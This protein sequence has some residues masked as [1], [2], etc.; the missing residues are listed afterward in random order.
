MFSGG[1]MSN[2]VTDG[3]NNQSIPPSPNSFSRWIKF[4]IRPSKARFESI[5]DIASTPRTLIGFAIAWGLQVVIGFIEGSRLQMELTGDVLLFPTLWVIGYYVLQIII[6][7][8]A[9]ILG[10]TGK[11][12]E[13][14]NLIALIAIPVAIVIALFDFAITPLFT[15]LPFYG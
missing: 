6:W 1:I 11:Y 13:Q 12:I 14:S 4:L 2:V 10:G 5:R 9:K 7:G 3:E 8:S 15:D